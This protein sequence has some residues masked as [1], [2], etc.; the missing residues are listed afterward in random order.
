[1]KENTSD[2]MGMVVYVGVKWNYVIQSL[3]STENTVG[4]TK[5]WKTQK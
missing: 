3:L 5:D 4:I 2:I 1:M